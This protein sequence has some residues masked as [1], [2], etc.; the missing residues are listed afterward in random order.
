[1]WRQVDTGGAPLWINDAGEVSYT[2]PV[3]DPQAIQTRILQGSTPTPEEFKS[4]YEWA[5][6]KPYQGEP[7]DAVLSGFR[8]MV[9]QD[10]AASSG[11]LED[12]LVM[13]AAGGAM[14]GMAAGAAGAGA[15]V[16]AEAGYGVNAAT[17]LAEEAAALGVGPEV[18]GT[19][20]VGSG[21]MTGTLQNLASTPTPSVP[22]P[23][24]PLIPQGVKDAATVAGLAS[25]GAGLAGLGTDETED[26]GVLGLGT[27]ETIAD[28]LTGDEV[29]GGISGGT[30]DP[31]TVNPGILKSIADALGTTPE[32]LT[33]LLGAFGPAALGALGAYQQGNTLK[34]LAKQQDARWREMMGMGAPYRSK[35]ADLYG[36]P[37]AF[38]SSQEVQVPVQQGTDA[39]A[40]SL[41][42]KVGN[43]IGNPGAMSEIQ[44]Y[45][46]NQLFGRLGQEKDR[47]AGF[48][49]LSAYNQAGASGGNNS[50]Q[51]Q[52]A[53][54]NADSGIWNSIGS[55]LANYF[56]P[57]S[58][59]ESI[60]KQMQG[61]NIFTVKG[62]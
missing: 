5:Y 6:G 50:L 57:P 24:A 18:F 41:S 22:T 7:M 8:T 45:A 54:M 37:N 56:N 60:L 3:D 10:A 59:L 42:T 61:S 43:P 12:T 34:D 1:M 4:W 11:G 23:D 53:G 27:D 15:G 21:T 46:S 26:A 20:A 13:L 29:P 39:L 51:A 44:N 58:S 14:G 36:N 30:F 62:P 48:G 31:S 16:G 9:E 38:L 52:M 17:G 2:Q 32:E 28:E 33:K 49:G 47:L 55:G 25:T 40:R 35:L 19:Q